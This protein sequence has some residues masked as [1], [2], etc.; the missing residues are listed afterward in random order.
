MTW[1]GSEFTWAQYL[2]SLPCV[3]PT[4][5]TEKAL[6][7]EVCL[8]APRASSDPKEFTLWEERGGGCRQIQVGEERSQEKLSLGVDWVPVN[9]GWAGRGQ[10]GVV[11]VEKSPQ[12]LRYIGV[13][14]I[15]CG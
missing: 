1:L 5:K 3:A 10:D 6:Q 14:S 12:E 15:H 11:G 7:T 4:R 9:P 13:S 2:H 8:G